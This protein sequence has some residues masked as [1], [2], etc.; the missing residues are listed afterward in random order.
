MTHSVINQVL[1]RQAVDVD[2]LIDDLGIAV[3]EPADQPHIIARSS[4]QYVEWVPDSFTE[5]ERETTT[6]LMAGLTVSQDLLLAAAFRACGYRVMPLETP[7]NQSLR[8]GKEFGNRGQCNPTYFT[9][10]NLIKFLTFLRDE[11]G[12]TLDEIKQRYV[13]VT[14]A[15]C[16]PC[17]FG[18]Y[19][20]EYRK[21]LRDSGFDGFRVLSISQTDGVSQQVGK[22]GGLQPSL[23]FA[24][25]AIQ[26]FIIGDVLNVMMYRLRP[27]EVNEGDTDK[28]VKQCRDILVKAF[29]KSNSLIR[30]VWRCKKILATV[31]V[32]RTQI[33]PRVAIIGEFW[34]MT[35]E[36]DGN[37]HLQRFL[38][39]EGAEVEVQL[40]T[41]WMLYLVWQSRYD[42]RLRLGLRSKD[43]SRRGLKGVNVP[44]KLFTLKLA[45]K[46]LPKVFG[47]YAR[48]MG[49]RDYE[50]ADMDEIAR[51]SHEFYNNNN[52]GGEGH[53]EVG[54][55]I[56][57]TQKNKVDMTISVKPFGCMPSSGVSDGVQAM[58][59]ERYPQ[60]IFLPIE[61]TGDGAVNVYSRI[62]MQLFK[63]KQLAQQEFANT[64]DQFG[65]SEAEYRQ[66]LSTLD[67]HSDAQHRSPRRTGCT[68]ADLAYEV[69][70][71]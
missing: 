29:E 26:S 52:R 48:L 49:L 47:F 38:E 6:L 65:V 14:A 21:A 28:A 64:L 69:C 32:D 42:T 27:Y 16:G 57:N 55:L 35:T 44:W 9:V 37:Y 5:S 17:R 13:F 50:F 1:E 11:K 19:V 25:K 51:I 4:E 60:A 54:K 66:R 70:S 34:A 61:T 45:E 8:F 43:E 30:A 58:I 31:K 7:D 12:M 15:A 3:P 36:G 63:A 56:D 23:R 67:W 10:G 59:T 40:I 68:G 46:A 22:G 2:G 41:G 71:Q 33:K 24:V 62:Q 39:E 53:M 20:S 18:T